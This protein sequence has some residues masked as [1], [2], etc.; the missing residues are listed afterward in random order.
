[1]NW[2]RKT[3]LVTVGGVLVL[4][5]TA[6][7]WPASL[8]FPEAALVCQPG[9][10]LQFRLHGV[11]WWVRARL[12]GEEIQL[13]RSWSEVSLCLPMNSAEGPHLLE[14][15]MGGMNTRSSQF[16]LEIDRTP[17]LLHL[18]SP[19]PD[20]VVADSHL[21]LSGRS[22]SG[23]RVH[24]QGADMPPLQLV[25]D[26]EGK[27]RCELQ[28]KP[29]WNQV[30][31]TA[32]DRAGNQSS[33]K[34]RIFSDREL[35]S[36]S[37]E[38]LESDGSSVP[39]R[40]KDAPTDSF[41]VRVL[42]RDD[43]GIRSLKYSLD[44]A[45]WVQPQLKRD[46]DTWK[47]VFAL[48]GLAEGTR[49]IRFEVTDQAGRKLE[50]EAEFLVDSSEELGE[51]TLT[52]GARGEDVRQLQRRLVEAR[53]LPSEAVQGLFD[54][55]VEAAIRRFQK[56]EG[57]PETGQVARATLRA[58]GPRILVNLARFEL[59]LDRPG[60]HPRRYP[61]ACG[62]ADWPTPTGR[63]VVWEKVKDPSWIPPDSPWAREAKT[64]PPGPD[65]P[66]GTRWIGLGWG[67]VGIHGTN[68]DWSIGS[69]S[70]HGCLRMHLEDVEELFELVRQDMP[71][72]VYSGYE[73]E[74]LLKRFWP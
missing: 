28:L 68:A 17:P 65:N 61:I 18:E 41:R 58:L 36:V 23:A 48:Q 55:Q 11:P 46:G 54:S 44:G 33:L 50:E 25:S 49:K 27:F 52:L 70:S 71:V 16:P 5:L 62:S 4:T 8:Q 72:T 73:Q 56:A 37:L 45:A 9:T 7:S 2:Q 53:Y 39:L 32:L 19:G 69:A 13:Q 21:P 14:I 66:L 20:S 6:L 51:K 29:G 38:R 59:L 15:E 63:F 26:K 30:Q 57:L 42:A 47:T 10:R 67:N 43:S 1:M 3:K 74:A 64:I 60:K 35:P 12:D 24:I 34:T 31:M 22:E 40:G